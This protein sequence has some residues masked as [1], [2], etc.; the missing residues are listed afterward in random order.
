MNL[1]RNGDGTISKKNLRKG[2]SRLGIGITDAQFGELMNGVQEA[3]ESAGAPV[4][5]DDIYFSDLI[6]VFEK[7]PS[8]EGAPINSFDM[9]EETRK[10]ED[11]LR[12]KHQAITSESGVMKSADGAALPGHFMHVDFSHQ[13]LDP[14]AETP[15]PKTQGRRRPQPH[16]SEERRAIRIKKTLLGKLEEKGK[17]ISDAFIALDADRDGMI[18]QHDMRRGLMMGLG[19]QLAKDELRLLWNIQFHPVKGQHT[20]NFS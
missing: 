6:H 9:G 17:S 7:I 3:Q 1:E 11:T 13:R 16:T 8:M 15:A 12:R 2:M 10:R 5:G 14:F 4:G 18:T 20:R 19:I